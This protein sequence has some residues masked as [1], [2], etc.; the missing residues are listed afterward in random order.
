MVNLRCADYGFDC[1]YE[2]EGSKEYVV[3]KFQEHTE[4][5]HGIEYEKESVMQLLLRKYPE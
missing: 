3:M 4:Q 2:I 1:K 5:E